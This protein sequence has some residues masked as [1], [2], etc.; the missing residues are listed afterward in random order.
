MSK[1]RG[2]SFDEKKQA[3]MDMMYDQATFYTLK[4]LEKLAPSKGVV[5]QSVKEVVEALVAENIISQEKVGA[6]Q[7]FWALRSQRIVKLITARDE[8]LALIDQLGGQIEDEEKELA[9]MESLGKLTV[10]EIDAMKNQY[11]EEVAKQKLLSAEL[12]ECPKNDPVAILEK[13]R[14]LPEL[15]DDANEWADKITTMRRKICREN[16]VNEEA[17]NQEF[18][19]PEEFEDV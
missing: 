1:K 5:S 15:D 9:R 2:L 3:I 8:D 14:K 13:K 18:G 11:A 7:L 4:E 19:L 10:E 17:F 16:G 12:A 6:Q